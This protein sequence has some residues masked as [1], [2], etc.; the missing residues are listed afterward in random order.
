[1]CCMLLLEAFEAGLVERG[2]KVAEIAVV[3]FGEFDVDDTFVCAHKRLLE[4][5]VDGAAV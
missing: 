2:S 4:T 3:L 1:M 5:A